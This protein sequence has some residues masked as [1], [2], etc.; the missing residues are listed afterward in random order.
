MATSSLTRA[1]LASQAWKRARAYI[2]EARADARGLLERDAD[3]DTTNKLRGRI[4][5]YT[6]LLGLEKAPAEAPRTGYDP[7]SADDA[8]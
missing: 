6:E 2:E 1:D 7:S 8:G 5:A 4:A 3:L